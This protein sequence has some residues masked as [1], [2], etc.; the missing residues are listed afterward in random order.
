M[1]AIAVSVFWYQA[2]VIRPS[3][4]DLVRGKSYDG[5]LGRINFQLHVAGT[6]VHFAREGGRW[7]YD[8]ACVK[9]EAKAYG[10]GAADI[11]RLD[12]WEY[13]AHTILQ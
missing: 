3:G 11:L 2:P 1:L 4:I 9:A 12:E 7:L 13:R 8:P 5:G 6:P 10:A